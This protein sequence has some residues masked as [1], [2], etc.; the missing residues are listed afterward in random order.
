MKEREKPEIVL[1]YERQKAANESMYFD[2][3]ELDE[4]FHY[5]AEVNDID[6]LP[7]VIALAKQLHPDDV[8]TVTIDAEYALIDDRAEDCLEMLKPVF[9][10]DNLLHLLLLSGA[11]ARLGSVST[12]IS[13]AERAMEFDDPLVA[14]DL[15]LGF[16]NADQC[17]VALRYYS[18][19]L[20]AV[21][22]DLRSILG[23]IYCLRRVGTP[24]EVLEYVDK[25]LEIDSFC[26]DAWVVKGGI[27]QEQE[28]WKEAEECCDYALAIQPDNTDSLMI[29][30]QCCLHADRLDEAYQL[31]TEAASYA[32]YDQRANI[33]LF[34]ARMEQDRK[35][36]QEAVEFAWKALTTNPD[37]L[38]LVERAATCFSHLGEN[39]T[40]IALFEDIFRRQG[41]E[42]SPFVLSMLADL[43]TKE[44]YADKT[45]E[46][47]ELMIKHDP[48]VVTYTMMAGV[49]L[50][51][52]KYHKAYS[53][54]LK[55]NEVNT[56]WQ[57]YILLAVCAHELG[58]YNAMMDHFT[59]AWCIVGD[60]ASK[61]IQGVS[62]P[63][64]RDLEKRGILNYATQ[65][66]DRNMLSAIRTIQKNHRRRSSA[67]DDSD[68]SDS[69][70]NNSASDTSNTSESD[71]SN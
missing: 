3:V 38:D 51:T 60:E 52:G 68:S 25:A 53:Y 19:C 6:A 1:Q 31:A 46:I 2:P 22:D 56:A 55:A 41:D 13:W 61:L 7:P 17:A 28:K 57:T 16:M 42:P 59:I 32:D 50:A 21:P 35:H 65:W 5:Y 36:P 44:G 10:E 66:R 29:K 39:E 26:V 24:E 40:A 71:K 43:Y 48:S 37:D 33:Y 23:I 67:S 14:Y 47:Y 58:W 9:S 30:A 8:V 12:A 18:R 63:T 54:L 70:T 15:G 64:W 45:M 34:L 62:E 69:E 49:C 27:Y 20:D 4:I 11:F